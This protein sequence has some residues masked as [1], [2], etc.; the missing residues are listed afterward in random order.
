MTRYFALLDGELGAYGVS[1]PDCPG[2][3]AMG[4]TVNEAYANAIDPWPNGRMI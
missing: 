2:C 4:E 3:S 1:F